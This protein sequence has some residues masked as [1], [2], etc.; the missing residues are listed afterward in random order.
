MLITALTPLWNIDIGE[1]PHGL[2]VQPDLVD[3]LVGGD[4]P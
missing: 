3:R 4:S 2:S 1:E